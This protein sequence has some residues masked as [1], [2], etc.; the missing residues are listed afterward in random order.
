MSRTRITAV[1]YGSNFYTFKCYRYR[2]RYIGP[3]A[4]IPSVVVIHLPIRSDSYEK[5]FAVFFRYYVS[6]SASSSTVPK[7]RRG[8]NS[9]PR[10]VGAAIRPHSQ[11]GPFALFVQDF[12]W[13]TF[14][15][16]EH[17]HRSAVTV[18]KKIYYFLSEE[19]KDRSIATIFADLESIST[20]WY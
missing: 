17:R 2:R 4:I 13:P 18:R 14:R 1:V 9:A 3:R 7:T 11:R 10:V 16:D 5:T 6:S 8:S 19:Q 20:R 12:R 15:D